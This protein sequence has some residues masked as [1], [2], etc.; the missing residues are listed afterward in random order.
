LA[1]RTLARSRGFTITAMAFQDAWTLDLER[2]RT[3][4]LHVVSEGRVI[5]FC[6][7]YLTVFR[8]SSGISDE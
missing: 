8:E 3:C 6:A 2:L 1:I 4:S 5:P 7:N